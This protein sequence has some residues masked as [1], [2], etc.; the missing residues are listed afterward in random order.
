MIKMK[1]IVKLLVIPL[2]SLCLSANANDLYPNPDKRADSF[3]LL[4]THLEMDFRNIGVSRFSARTDQTVLAKVDKISSVRL[5]LQ[6]LTVDSIYC[7]ETKCNFTYNF[8]S[9]N[10]TLPNIKNTNDTIRLKIYYQGT[11][12]R[13]ASGFGGFYFTNDYAFAIGVGFNADP[14]PFGRSWFPCFDNFIMKSTY[15]YDVVTDTGYAAVCGGA[16]IS[17]TITGNTIRWKYRLNQPIPSYLASIS[18]SRYELLEGQ[19]NTLQG[20]IPYIL[21]AQEKDTQNLNG[22]FANFN[23]AVNAFI[24]YYGNY[25]WDR[26]GY[27][28]VPFNGGAMEH[29]C[30]ISYPLFAIDGSTNREDLMAHE[31]AHHWWGNN[32][33]CKT[34]EDM[35]INE[36]WASYSE[37]LFNEYVYG[38]ARYRQKVEETHRNVLQ[39]A[40][41]A[42]GEILPVSGIGH[43]NTYGRHVYRK[44]ADIAHSLRFYM[45]D[46]AFFKAIKHIMSSKKFG[47]MDSKELLDSF[48]T[49]TSIDLSHFYKGWVIGKGFPHLAI[50]TWNTRKQNGK[51]RT[52]VGIL[53]RNRWDGTP[54]AKIPVEVSFLKPDFSYEN[55]MVFATEYQSNFSFDL[56]YEPLWVGLDLDAKLSDATTDTFRTISSKGKYS[57][58][59]GLMELDVKEIGAASFVHV[60]HNWLAADASTQIGQ[61]P[62]LSRDR[63]WTISGV[64]KDGFK[65]SATIQY[66]G[67]TTQPTGDYFLDNQL[68]KGTEDSLTLMY[69]ED[70]FSPWVKADATKEMGPSK[71]DRSGSFTIN[72][73]KIGEYALAMFSQSLASNEVNNNASKIDI[74][75]NPVKDLVHL[76]F[77]SFNH[78]GYIIITDSTGKIILKKSIRNTQNNLDIN[79]KDW[80]AGTYAVVLQYPEGNNSKASF[81]VVK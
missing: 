59:D 10:C 13:D 67:R 55:K 21:A 2:F 17:K 76:D 38:K 39:F 19:M 8:K 3:E 58:D 32:V 79:T 74:Y 25:F 18:V 69:R 15:S 43:S 80:P 48:Q 47:N 50:K 72:Q 42:D 16:L 31:L 51:F 73:L 6:R 56:D 36:G 54:H 68:I 26:L 65:A 12:G 20:K 78:P 27:H 70:M 45:G 75:P 33:T 37:K 53:Q 81:V 77:V 22:S 41:I 34:Q 24:H 57:F 14:H 66:N 1:T 63:Y 5:D 62:V 60:T 11:P 23:E 4:H 30:N 46:T 29:A 9:I 49:F 52:D 44:G 61:L 40:H 64:F 7:D 28:C 71:F 35:W